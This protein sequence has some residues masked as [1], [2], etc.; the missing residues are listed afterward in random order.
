[1]R[2]FKTTPAGTAII[3][4]FI[5]LAAMMPA[6][7]EPV[8]VNQGS[9]LGYVFSNRGNCFIILP[10]HV[11]GDRR[12][13]TLRTSTPSIF[14]DAK[15][16]KS[17]MPGAD[18]SIGFVSSD[19]GGRCSSTWEQMQERTDSLL[20]K[21]DSAVLVRIDAQ[22]GEELIPMRIVNRDYDMLTAVIADTNDKRKIY[23]GTSGAILKIGDVVIGMAVR[24][25]DDRTAR[26]LR[27]DEIKSEVGRLIEA[28]E[29]GRAY[30]TEP[31]SANGNDNGLCVEKDDILIRAVTCNSEPVSPENACSSLA[32]GK[33][34]TPVILRMNGPAELFV[35]LDTKE[36]A[37]V[38]H[39]SMKSK[40]GDGSTSAP[41]RVS[42]EVDSS[43]GNSPRWRYFGDSDMTPFGDLEVDNG[44]A[45]FARRIKISIK[46]QWDVGKPIRLDCLAISPAASQ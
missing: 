27:I 25:S 7:G 22:G 39:I 33:E 8:L 42:I 31:P 3:T 4:L 38:G 17:F 44:S 46:S 23:Q 34:S 36:G 32:R 30:A 6:A 24:A 2:S 18:L 9:G 40:A 20:D 19:L 1:M 35:E 26:V 21:T 29:Q 13:V 28:R 11:H 5:I 14:G 12:V 10:E 15:I 41:R 45:P 37:A 43:S 16:F